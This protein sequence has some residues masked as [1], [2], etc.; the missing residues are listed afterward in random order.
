[1]SKVVTKH[2]NEKEHRYLLASAINENDD[3]KTSNTGSFTVTISQTTTVVSDKRA[4]T[5]SVILFS[6]TT[7]S[8]ATEI[9]TMY[10]SANGKETFTVTHVSSVTADR[11]FNYV[12]V[13]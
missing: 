13:G 6:P 4:G 1:M 10:V 2:G 8:A 7:A 9:S 12:I 5:N 11:T 3:G